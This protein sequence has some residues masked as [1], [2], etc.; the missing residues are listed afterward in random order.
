MPHR[1]LLLLGGLRMLDGDGREL[2][3][4]SRKGRALLARVALAGAACVP[5]ERLA[6]GFWADAD[7]ARARQ[8][9]R[10]S[11]SELRREV[12]PLL[13][14]RSQRLLF[15]ADGC[16]VDALAFEALAGRTDPYSLERAVAMFAGPLLDGFDSVCGD[17]FD[18]WLHGERH[19]FAALN[20]R[21]CERLLHHHVERHDHDAAARIAEQAVEFDPDDE[22]FWRAWMRALHAAGRP[23]RA[24]QVFERCRSTL[25]RRLDA[26]PGAETRALLAALRDAAQAV[27]APSG[28]GR[29]AATS[30][31]TT[32]S[33]PTSSAATSSVATSSVAT[34]SMAAPSE[35]APSGAAPFGA[36]PSEAVPSGAAPFAAMPS[37]PPSRP[38]ALPMVAVMPFEVQG[39]VDPAFA[40][41]LAAELIG[42]LSRIAGFAIVDGRL[43][44]RDADLASEA[45]RTIVRERR[46]V[47]V[48]AGRLE[49]GR[50]D[51][52]LWTV[53]LIDCDDGRH[54]WSRRVELDGSSPERRDELIAAMVARIEP[55]ILMA[56][57][58][59]RPDS[60]D[61]DPWHRVRQAFAA[62]FARGWSE[63]AVA[64]AV[65]RYRDA[66]RADPAF[67]L[68]HAHKALVL[69]LAAKMGLVAA[70]AVAEAQTA[71][72]RAIALAPTDSEVLGVAGCA[73][74]DLGDPHRGE[75]L[76]ERA[77]EQNPD[78]PQAWAA[79][80]AC[81]LGMA[82]ISDGLQSLERG[83]RL[84]SSDYRRTVWLT[85]MSRG[86]LYQR[87][88]TEAI[89]TA[90]AA[91][92]S[93]VFFYPAWLALAAAQ[94]QA[95][96][97]AQA[98]RALAE[99]RR[100]RPQ[101]TLAE[102]RPWISPRVA[103]RMAEVW[104]VTVD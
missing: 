12:G 65:Q 76:L 67:A 63:E 13:V 29:S 27:D 21:D 16:V 20:R 25:R 77:V 73:I 82:R 83:V 74:A 85:L 92:R 79:L 89:D 93:D 78:N 22:S 100:I 42:A 28:A 60:E 45:S 7:E 55:Q 30:S 71:A 64:T 91:V 37:P 102:A 31:A 98:R 2:T 68:A 95:G 10:Q 26:E 34:P 14:D 49:C 66:I 9:L 15:E 58:Q 101:L 94:F 52:C 48:V 61:D 72:E 70:E 86:L 87:R 32:S 56:R 3:I 90:R 4:A 40:A 75:T 46:V 84:G 97:A 1:E 47:F 33:I 99:A 44:F 36:S 81:R 96:N 50:D 39:Q 54:L 38:H 24:M 23:H 88:P 43:L 62:L 6:G 59:G 19:R 57:V 53:R 41:T 8:S 51:P 18:D 35:A 80:G 5:R 104:P 103:A 11:L 17:E 69:A